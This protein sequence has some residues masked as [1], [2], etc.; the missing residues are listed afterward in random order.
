MPTGQRLVKRLCILGSHHGKNAL[1]G[2]TIG[3]AKRHPLEGDLR[4]SRL[5]ERKL[6]YYSAQ[7]G[8]PDRQLHWSPSLHCDGFRAHL[9]FAPLPIPTVRIRMLR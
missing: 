4:I 6:R 3:F 1:N 8:L 2:V 5:P 9:H 7:M